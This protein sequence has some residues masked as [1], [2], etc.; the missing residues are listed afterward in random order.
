MFISFVHGVCRIFSLLLQCRFGLICFACNLFLSNEAQKS[1]SRP[2]GL[3]AWGNIFSSLFHNKLLM[4]SNL[5]TLKSTKHCWFVL[6]N[7]IFKCWSACCTF[8]FCRLILWLFPHNC[9]WN[10]HK[11][12]TFTGQWTRHFDMSVNRQHKDVLNKGFV[13]IR[14]KQM[15]SLYENVIQCHLELLHLK[16]NLFFL[17]KNQAF[18]Y[19]KKDILSKFIQACQNSSLLFGGLP[20]EIFCFHIKW[21]HKLSESCFAI[22][23]N[24]TRPTINQNPTLHKHKLQ[25]IIFLWKWIG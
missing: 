20:F 25:S 15:C 24:F 8:G 10:H 19:S 18:C 12:T 6:L 13:Q 9:A 11:V 4:I 7:C 1:N 5:V 16:S 21:S 3:S 23:T 2:L 14:S 17:I 22:V